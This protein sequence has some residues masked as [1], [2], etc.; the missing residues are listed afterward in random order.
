M[1]HWV[2]VDVVH[3]PGEIRA[4]PNQVLPEAALPDVILPLAGYGAQTR[5][6][7]ARLW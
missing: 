6:A 5:R 1:L 2:E 3:V 7:L 4:V